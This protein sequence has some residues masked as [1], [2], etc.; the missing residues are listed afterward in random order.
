M[1]GG[2]GGRLHQRQDQ[3]V[4]RARTGRP[5]RQLQRGSL[6]RHQDPTAIRERIGKTGVPEEELL[7]KTKTPVVPVDRPDLN[8]CPDEKS[9]EAREVCTQQ[10]NGGL[11]T[12]E[13]MLDVCFGGKES[14]RSRSSASC[15][16]R[17]PR[18]KTLHQ[19]DFALQDIV[20]ARFLPLV[21]QACTTRDSG[22]CGIDP[23]IQRC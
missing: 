8:N 2:V 18:K 7:F 13:C 10:S 6:G 16:P 20:E 21:D 22:D 5:L 1:D 23:L 4:G 19:H 14:L 3:D 17:R 11:P 9:K 12:Q 15:C